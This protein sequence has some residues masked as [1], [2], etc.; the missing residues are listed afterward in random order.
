MT[1]PGKSHRKRD[2]NPGSSA[3]ET[4]VLTARPA[5]RLCNQ[6]EKT[7]PLLIKYK[8]S[9][10]MHMD[11]YESTVLNLFDDNYYCTFEV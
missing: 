9:V 7:A 2:S 6:G 10:G 3:P 5:R 8:T 1:R 4:D 11:V